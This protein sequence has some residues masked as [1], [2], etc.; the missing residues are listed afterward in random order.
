MFTGGNRPGGLISS[1]VYSGSPGHG[2]GSP[3]EGTTTAI[4]PAAVPILLTWSCSRR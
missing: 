4:N 1:A 2:D 3:G